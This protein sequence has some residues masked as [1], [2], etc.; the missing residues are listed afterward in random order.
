MV[1]TSGMCAVVSP[2]PGILP[3]TTGTNG[4]GDVSFYFKKGKSK[5][6]NTSQVS[7]LRDLKEVDTKEIK[8]IKK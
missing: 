5:K 2:Q 6:G 8:D 3:G 1:S 7:D 4:S